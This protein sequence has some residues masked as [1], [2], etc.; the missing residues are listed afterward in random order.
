MYLEKRKRGGEEP[1]PPPQSTFEY[2]FHFI[3]PLSL[4]LCLNHG[5]SVP[6]FFFQTY[7]ARHP[8]QTVGAEPLCTSTTRNKIPHCHSI[9]NK[10]LCNFLPWPPI[11][12]D[13]LG[14]EA[15]GGR[16]LSFLGTRKKNGMLRKRDTHTLGGAGRGDEDEGYKLP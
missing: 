10:G 3:R 4:S 14:K 5:G 9:R 8:W 12:Y 11:S 6:R 2:S 15:G 1:L 16:E 7:Y 13:N